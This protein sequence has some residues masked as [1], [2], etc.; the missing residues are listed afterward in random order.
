MRRRRRLRVF[1]FVSPIVLLAALICAGGALT[2]RPSWYQP[3]SIDYALI[4]ADKHAHLKIENDIS[5]ALNGNSPVV[6]ELDEEQVNRWIAG[7]QQFWPGEVPSLAPFEN[8]QV[9][10]LADGSVRLAALVE[11]A[12][13]EAVLSIT[14]RFELSGEDVIVKW[15]GA[16]AGALPAPTA[17]LNELAQ[18]I[19]DRLNLDDRVLSGSEFTLPNEATWPNGKRRF[20]VTQIAIEPGSARVELKPLIAP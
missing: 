1:L 19:A 12:N 20:R 15:E 7:R 9:N 14:F 4:E 13:V 17:L 3:A 10:F 5:A 8:P 18:A 6:I 2:C 16:R 11:L